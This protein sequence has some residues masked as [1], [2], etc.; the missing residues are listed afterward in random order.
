MRTFEYLEF[1]I[2]WSCNRLL[3]FI[4]FKNREFLTIF[5]KI[6]RKL[7]LQITFLS[8]FK[9]HFKFKTF[10]GNLSS[11]Y[12]PKFNIKSSKKKT[13]TQIQCSRITSLYFPQTH[14]KW[15]CFQHKNDS[16]H[17][18]DIYR[19]AT[20]ITCLIQSISKAPIRYK[21]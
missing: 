9:F 3:H 6:I 15:V 10:I 5:F 8:L 4:A 16:I 18:T 19:S 20:N 2:S 21:V 1:I 11:K 12:S 17:R 14:R 7:L 13:V